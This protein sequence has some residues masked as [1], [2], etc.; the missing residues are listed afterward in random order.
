[1]AAGGAGPAGAAR[2][3]AS[4]LQGHPDWAERL[5]LP[6]L[7][8]VARPLSFIAGAAVLAA[9][10]VVPTLNLPFEVHSVL[11]H[12][13]KRR[14][15]PRLG[16]RYT[17]LHRFHYLL[18][19]D[20]VK[21]GDQVVTSGLLSIFPA[22]IPVG[23]VVAIRKQAFGLYQE[24]EVEPAVDFNKLREVLVVLAPPPPPDPDAGKRPPESA[25]GLSVP[26]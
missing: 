4:R 13:E 6:R 16:T 23:K 7:F 12:T 20:E 10:S 14:L 3:A 19:Q 5:L 22:D 21:V 17:D 18:R 9:M 1:M 26:R 24:V 2:A 15:I 25:R 11:A 8:A